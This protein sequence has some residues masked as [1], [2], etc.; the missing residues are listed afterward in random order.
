MCGR[1]ANQYTLV[2]L[3][4]ITEP[5]IAPISNLEPRFNFAPMQR[6]IVVRPDKEGL[7]F[8]MQDAGL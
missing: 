7:Q 2:D 6:G 3:Y 4:R 5:Y 8:P 1:F